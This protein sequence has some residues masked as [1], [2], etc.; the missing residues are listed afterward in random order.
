MH[1][2]DW[3]VNSVC[4]LDVARGFTI[5]ATHPLPGSDQPIS[6]ADTTVHYPHDADD[7]LRSMIPD[8]RIASVET[9]YLKPGPRVA[10]N[11]IRRRSR[12]IDVFLNL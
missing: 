8:G 9:V 2:L 10:I 3:L 5:E 4:I 6:S 12:T 1:M 7:V 11:E